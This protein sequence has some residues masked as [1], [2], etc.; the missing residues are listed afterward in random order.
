MVWTGSAARKAQARPMAH[1]VASRRNEKRSVAP[2]VSGALAAELKSA[3]GKV[4]RE[5]VCRPLPYE[6]RRAEAVKG[7]RRPVR[8]FPQFATVVLL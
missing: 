7:C 3:R 6:C 4:Q 2:E 1:G 8:M 5:E